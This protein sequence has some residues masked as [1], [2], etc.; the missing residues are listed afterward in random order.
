MDINQITK[1]INDRTLTS[2]KDRQKIM[3]WLSKQNELV[4]FEIF[5]L[6]KN[7]FHRLKGAELRPDLTMLD[8]VSLLLAAKEF[9]TKSTIEN[10]KNRSKSFG[11]LKNISYHRAIQMRKPRKKQVQEKLMDKHGLIL[12]LIE[13]EKLSSR[14]VAQYLLSHHRLKVSHTTI[15]NFYNSIKKEGEKADGN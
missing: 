2:L 12:N 3:K 9:I 1:I 11:F 14:E 7:H 4:L 5:K 13:R 8:M 6:K 10:K 15:W